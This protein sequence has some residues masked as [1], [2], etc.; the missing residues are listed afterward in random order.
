M[1]GCSHDTSS[2]RWIMHTLSIPQMK[3]GPEYHPN[4]LFFAECAL[5]HAG[6]ARGG[7]YAIL[8]RGAARYADRTDDLAAIH[9]RQAAFDGAH[10]ERQQAQPRA[11]ARH[12]V[13]ESL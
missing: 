13:L 11:P 8:L 2:T 3:K 5:L 12:A 7:D 10:A 9:D 1:G 6:E 4:P